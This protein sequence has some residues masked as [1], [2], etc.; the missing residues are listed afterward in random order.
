MTIEQVKR[1]MD[2]RDDSIWLMKGDCLERMKEIPDCSVDA[3]ICDIPYGT[4]KCKWD[5]IIPFTSMWDELERVIKDSGAILLFGNEP[6]SST[7]RVSNL[8]LY[9]YDWYWEKNSASNFF[10]MKNQ[11]AKNTENISVFYKTKPTYNPQYEAGKGYSAVTGEIKGEQQDYTAKKKT[12]LGNDGTKYLPKCI[13][14]NIKILQRNKIHQ[15]QKPVEL[16]EYLIKTYTNEGETVLDFTMGSGTTG[17]AAKNLNRNFIGIEMDDG[18][19]D[20]SKDRIIGTESHKIG[21][22]SP[23]ELRKQRRQQVT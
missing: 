17:V 16:M 9:R 7:L 18:Y 20:I 12:N 6:F 3:I 2:F 13:I 22:I 21:E 10:N 1:S 5:I 23:P 19:F 14:K 8:P 4:V 15:T 11:P